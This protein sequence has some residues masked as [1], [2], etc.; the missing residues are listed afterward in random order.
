MNQTMKM[1]AAFA[2]PIEPIASEVCPIVLTECA[3]FRLPQLPHEL[4]IDQP[5]TT[6]A[7]QQLD[8]ATPAQQ[9]IF[10]SQLR[11][12]SRSLA[13]WP[14]LA[15]S[16]FPTNL[17]ALIVILRFPAT[18]LALIAISKSQLGVHAQ[19]QLQAF[20]SAPH[21]LSAFVASLAQAF[22]VR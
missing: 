11:F 7:I 15:I 8:V 20:S 9:A 12:I 18:L 4:S 13:I 16:Q 14:V 6:F 3:T 2:N 22:T 21:Q 10:I 19:H 1:F 17:L 5:T